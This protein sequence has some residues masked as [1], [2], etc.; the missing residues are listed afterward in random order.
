VKRAVIVVAAI[1]LGYLGL[2]YVALRVMVRDGWE[3]TYRKDS[4]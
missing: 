4:E 3:P 2:V 1:G